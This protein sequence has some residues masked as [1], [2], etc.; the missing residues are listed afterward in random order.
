MDTELAMRIAPPPA[1]PLTGQLPAAMPTPPAPDPPIKGTRNSLPVNP[2]GLG[3]APGLFPGAPP[4]GPLPGSGVIGGEAP[5]PPLYPPAPAKLG[6][7][8]VASAFPR[9]GSPERSSVPEMV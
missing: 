7:R 3:G 5:T 8:V 4:A 9:P 1:P 2:P 6:T